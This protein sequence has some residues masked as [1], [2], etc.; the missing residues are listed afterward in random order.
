VHELLE[1]VA[2][3]RVVHA[4]QRDQLAQLRAARADASV[5]RRI[6]RFT[7][8]DDVTAS[9]AMDRLLRTAHVVV[10][11]G[12]SYRNPPG[13]GARFAERA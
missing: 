8:P 13:A 6:L 12:H 7:S 4:L 3:E 1:P 2:G 9:A 5:E 11:E 10:L